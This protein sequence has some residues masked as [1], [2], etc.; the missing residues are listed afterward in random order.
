MY[1][2]FIATTVIGLIYFIFAKRR[3]DFFT[4]AFF[5]CIFY[6]IPGYLGIILDY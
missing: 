3:F 1:D 2:L 6:F 4:L 5:S